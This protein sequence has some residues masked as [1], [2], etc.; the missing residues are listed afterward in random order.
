MK[1]EED[2]SGD[3]ETLHVSI[4]PEDGR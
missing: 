3:R 4:M 2:E 1:R